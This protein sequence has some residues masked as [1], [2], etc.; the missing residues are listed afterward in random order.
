MGQAL[1]EVCNSLLEESN[2]VLE[3]FNWVEDDGR[4][5]NRVD[6][7]LRAAACPAGI[8]SATDL[9]DI[10]IQSSLLIKF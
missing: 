4:L 6:I 8:N 9:T 1:L 5:L 2:L 10:V 3:I 7:S